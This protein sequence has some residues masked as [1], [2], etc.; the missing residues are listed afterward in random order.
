MPSRRS[1]LLNSPT[2][3]ARVR[4]LAR[5]SMHGS[6]NGAPAVGAAPLVRKLRATVW[7]PGNTA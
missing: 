6:K 2:P 4:R 5:S 7:L 1:P 3:A